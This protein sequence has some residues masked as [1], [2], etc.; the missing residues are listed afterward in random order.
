MR[1]QDECGA[2][3]RERVLPADRWTAWELLADPGELEGWLADE[4][5]LELVEEGAEGT[6]RWTDGSVRRVVVEEVVPGRRLALRWEAAA[7]GDDAP[8]TLV[9]LTLDDHGDGTL[10]RVVELQ[11]V[12]L[13]AHGAE[14]PVVTGGRAGGGPVLLAA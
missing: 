2:V 4:V 1:L 12:V 11:L 7:P 5:D 3:R 9:E 14:L 13:E 10:L 8:D 6:F